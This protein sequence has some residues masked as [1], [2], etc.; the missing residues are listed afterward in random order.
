MEMAQAE[1]YYRLGMST[2]EFGNKKLQTK[3]SLNFHR[4]RKILAGWKAEDGAP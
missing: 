4:E 1:A 3:L 2:R